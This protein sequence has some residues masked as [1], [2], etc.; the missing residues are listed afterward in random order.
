MSAQVLPFPTTHE[1]WLSKAQIAMHFGRTT[2][3]VE[4]RMRDGMPHRKDGRSRY[5]RT[6]FRLSEVEA[7]MEDRG[8]TPDV[9]VASPA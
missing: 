4:L 6:M 7:W 5:A 2:R 9:H 1:P 8:R 3:W